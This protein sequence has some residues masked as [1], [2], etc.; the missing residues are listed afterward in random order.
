MMRFAGITCLAVF[1]V[2]AGIQRFL[3]YQSYFRLLLEMERFFLYMKSEIQYSKS[4]MP[5]FFLAASG[6]EYPRM[7]SWI[8]NI[9]KRLEGKE[10]GMRQSFAEVWEEA[11]ATETAFEINNPEL[12]EAFCRLG[13]EIGGMDMQSQLKYLEIF[14]RDVE[15]EIV[16]VKEQLPIRKKLYLSLGVMAG[17]FVTVVLI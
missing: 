7:R 17:M 10:R 13:D 1:C 3:R 15:R 12:A 8:Q 11:A 2:L 14:L 4:S 5:E 9:A 6:R 16:S